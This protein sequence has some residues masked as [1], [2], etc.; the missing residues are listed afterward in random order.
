MDSVEKW[1]TKGKIVVLAVFVGLVIDGMDL[2]M[3]SLS[4]PQIKASSPREQGYSV[5]G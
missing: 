1:D 2:Q 3:L 4:L 5:P